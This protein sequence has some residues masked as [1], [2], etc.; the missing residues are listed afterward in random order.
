MHEV[1]PD[2]G[3]SGNRG[4]IWKRPATEMN[5]YRTGSGGLFE[6]GD[7]II[8]RARGSGG[9]GNELFGCRRNRRLRSQETIII[10]LSAENG[11]LEGYIGCVVN[12]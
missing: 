10:P 5:E 3:H 2:D 1:L 12:E 11:A 8:R 9:D 6:D 4:D 7:V